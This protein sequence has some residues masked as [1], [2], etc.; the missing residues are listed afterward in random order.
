M[1]M[2][3]CL[4]WLIWCGLFGVAYLSYS[5]IYHTAGVQFDEGPVTYLVYSNFEIV[6]NHKHDRSERFKK[7]A[8]MI[9][10]I[11]CYEH[12]IIHR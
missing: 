5:R 1:M 9:T 10:M 4:V 12:T 6:Q 2:V 11:L 7:K 8:E 3:D